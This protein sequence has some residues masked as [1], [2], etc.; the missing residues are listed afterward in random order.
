MAH[1]QADQQLQDRPLRAVNRHDDN[2]RQPT[3]TTKHSTSHSWGADPR[4]GVGPQQHKAHT[5]HESQAR[6]NHPS[7][8]QQLEGGRRPKRRPP[9][10][11]GVDYD[12]QRHTQ[13]KPC[14]TPHF[15]PVPIDRVIA[16]GDNRSRAIHGHDFHL[17][18]KRILDLFRSLANRR[19][20]GILTF[21]HHNPRDAHRIPQVPFR[22][23]S[24]RHARIELTDLQHR[25]CLL[26]FIIN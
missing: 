13:T 24:Q 12:H 16:I 9:T 7:N 2:H 5:N 23:A 1:S 20:L 18:P 14:P 4:K 19:I 6:N 26:T 22:P 15:D 8:K 17:S 10:P 25:H 3:A 21:S 11:P